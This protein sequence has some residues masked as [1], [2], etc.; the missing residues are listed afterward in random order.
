MNKPIV[1]FHRCYCVSERYYKDR[2][3]MPKIDIYMA[4]YI[5][6]PQEIHRIYEDY[7]ERIFIYKNIEDAKKHYRRVS[8][9]VELAYMED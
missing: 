5:T 7:E 8:A 2:S 1:T 6:T 4:K 3:I 9:A